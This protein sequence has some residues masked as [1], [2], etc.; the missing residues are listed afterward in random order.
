MNE[1]TLQQALQQTSQAFAILDANRSI[2]YVN[3]A[4]CTLF[5]YDLQTVQGQSIDLIIPPDAS[6]GVGDR[7]GDCQ[8]LYAQPFQG[9]VRRMRQD[10]STL[11]VMLHCSALCNAEGQAEGYVLTYTDIAD[12][13][14]TELALQQANEQLSLALDASQLSLWDMDILQD[15]ASVDARWGRMLGYPAT[16]QT[17]RATSMLEAVHPDD[18][19]RIY[20][21][22]MEVL[23]GQNSRFQQEFRVR[24]AQHGWTWIRCTG[25]VV[26]RSDAGVALRAIGTNQDITERKSS[27]ALIVNAANHDWLTGLPNRFSLTHHLAAALARAQRH[28]KL[29]AVCMIDLD[30]FKPVNDTWGH[31]AGDYLLQ[32]LAR[33]LQ[34]LLRKTDFVARLG[35]DEF[36]IVM[37]DLPE[38]GTLTQL[39]AALQRLHRAVESPFLLG[40]HIEAEVGMT[41]GL[42]LFPHD[43]IEPDALMR[44]ADAAMYQAKQHKSTRPRWWHMVGEENGYA[45]EESS[46]FEVYGSEAAQLL[47]KSVRLIHTAADHYVQQFYA[48][49]NS[50]TAIQSV[51]SSLGPEE[52]QGL[53]AAHRNFMLEIL[54]PDNTAEKIGQD[55]RRLGHTH[56]LV[57]VTPIML[58]QSVELFRRTF[59]EQLNQTLL[60]I[61]QR[62]RLLEIIDRRLQDQL[63]AQLEASALVH[64]R[65]LDSIALPMP[66]Q[67]SLWADAVNS[68]LEQLGSLPGMQAVLLMRLMSNGVFVPENSSGPLGELVAGRLQMPGSEAVVDP[69]SERGQGLTAVAWRSGRICTSASY[70]KDKRYTLWHQQASAVQIRSTMSI[71][72]RNAEG[73]TVA[74]I[75]LFGAYPNQFE[76]AS[77]LQFAQGLQH[78]WE[79]I[80]AACTKPAAAIRQNLA[81]ALRERLFAGGLTMYLQPLVELN[82]GKVLK[83]E[84][85]ARLIKEDGQVV[86]PGVFLPLL[87]DADL[88]HLFRL[89]LDKALVQ[90]SELDRQGMQIGISL[91]IAPSTLQDEDCPHWVAEALR[92]HHIAPHR[93]SLELLETGDIAPLAQDRAIERLRQTGIKLAMDDLG[94]GYSSLQRLSTL[95]FDTIKID[96]SLT[97][98]LRKTPLTSLALMRAILQ[99]GQDLDRQVVVEGL[100][101][102]GMQEASRILGASIGQGYSLARPMSQADFIHWQRHFRLPSDSGDITTYLG[103]LAQHWLY[104]QPSHTH[105]KRAVQD[106]PLQHFLLRQLQPD[107]QALAWHAAC[108]AAQHDAAA[109]Q[110]L[111]DW[112]VTQ[113]LLES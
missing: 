55:S 102:R 4:F 77:M 33:R 95:P 27:E 99:L 57:G 15:T 72:V 74:V 108:H 75:S 1:L 56:S 82:S 87:G 90:L 63:H 66:H 40:K 42:S 112:L 34:G 5:G 81:V 37:E 78:R 51:L 45:P 103:A 109:S 26:A 22:S 80:L 65:Y 8:Q 28:D 71:P 52:L 91:N 106:C 107:A 110:Q 93:L 16:A 17:M 101:D 7:A 13:K 98:N 46:H 92:R 49:S 48:Q 100:E 60:P 31:Q 50:N 73:L 44:Q 20:R 70:G 24:N 38:E 35:G 105:G 84:A 21:A 113:M 32:E 29:V 2:R 61:R 83:V 36:V 6:D 25:K 30:D 19:P 12:R 62:Y 111:T 11:T 9:E 43:G 96:Q 104:T 67:G 53:E 68:E 64:A 79:L 23:K 47:R 14:A 18:Y 58:V 59:S 3:P 86:S 54:S 69:N 76:S 94:S 88:D 39:E 41:V 85:L 10:G 89:G 97:L